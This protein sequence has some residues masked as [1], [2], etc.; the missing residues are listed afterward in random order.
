MDFDAVFTQAVLH[1]EEAEQRASALAEAIRRKAEATRDG[2][3]VLGEHGSLDPAS[4]Q[5][6]A[7]HQIPFWTERMTLA[8]L[9][10]RKN[11]G[12]TLQARNVGFNVKWPETENDEDV[13]CLPGRR[14]TNDPAATHLTLEDARVRSLITQIAPWVPG[15][16]LAAL[17]LGGISDKTAGIWSLWRVSLSTA[18]GRSQ[19]MLPVFIDD[20]GRALLPTARRVW[21][22]L[23]EE[24]LDKRPLRPADVDVSLAHEIFEKTRQLAESH[25]RTLLDEL[26]LTHDQRIEREQRKGEQAFEARERAIRRVGL[27][28]VK[29]Y[30]MKELAKERE[31]WRRRLD[32]L[33]HATPK[34]ITGAH[35]SHRTC[36]RA[37]MKGWRSKITK[38]FSKEI[39]AS[40]PI[41]LVADP[42]E[43]LLEQEILEHLSESGFDLIVLE[44]RVRFRFI[45]E[46]KYRCKLG[47]NARAVVVRLPDSNPLSAPADILEEASSTSR[48]LKFSIADIFPE[49]DPQIISQITLDGFDQ[50]YSAYHLQAPKAFGASQTTDFVLRHVFEIVPEL[51]KSDVDFLRMLLQRHYRGD[52]LPRS[53]ATFLTRKLQ[54]R[55][56]DW[57]IES[58]LLDRDQFFTFLNER[59]PKFVLSSLRQNRRSS[60]IVRSLRAKGHPIWPRRYPRVRRQSLS[61]GSSHAL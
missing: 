27:E 51:V 13:W 46:T 47:A 33:K 26:Q 22:L 36:R 2:A 50:L 35:G 49:L 48:I 24:D 32:E 15:R 6:I 41:T 7:D 52:G 55:F 43:L 18:D 8:W 5:R 44:D 9:R 60:G 37:G 11:D 1:P 59:W 34:S 42:D 20:D 39:A 29:Q 23:I 28:Q 17:E 30:R 58:I 53:M 19:R 21:D 3:K 54:K 12:A 38:E 10:D 61:R 57:P 45:F 40:C 31:H 56:I 4:A 14:R 25:G 16:S